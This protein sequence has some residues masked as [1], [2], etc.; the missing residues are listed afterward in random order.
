MILELSYRSSGAQIKVKDHGLCED[1][2][3]G[4]ANSD[5][6][7]DAFDSKGR[8]QAPAAW[9]APERRPVRSAKARLSNEAVRA[10][11]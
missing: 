7:G 1:R 9:L 3:L 6:N 11:S 5:L 2:F 10:V 8:D 4:R